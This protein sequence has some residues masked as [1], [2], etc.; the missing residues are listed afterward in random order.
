MRLP[1]LPLVKRH[2]SLLATTALPPPIRLCGCTFLSQ[3]LLHIAHE[4]HLNPRSFPLLPSLFLACEGRSSHPAS[5]SALTFQLSI[6]PIPT[7]E[8]PSALPVISISCRNHSHAY[9]QHMRQDVQNFGSN[10]AVLKFASFETCQPS[11]V[12]LPCSP[13]ET[14][15]SDLASSSN[16][17]SRTLQGPSTIFANLPLLKASKQDVRAH[18]HQKISVKRF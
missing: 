13:T 15:S 17:F 12:G 2:C 7:F 4:F 16:S 3:R 6:C 10:F 8:C 1:T 5:T 9:Q 18:E 11:N 14:P